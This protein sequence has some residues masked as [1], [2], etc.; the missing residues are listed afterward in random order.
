LGK[1]EGPGGI[2]ESRAAREREKDVIE[3]KDERKKILTSSLPLLRRGKDYIRAPA[4]T[5]RK[6]KREGAKGKKKAASFPGGEKSCI[7]RTVHG[8]KIT[9]QASRP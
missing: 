3:E 5:K 4:P 6:G 7:V 9:Q 2:K 8:Q 1:R